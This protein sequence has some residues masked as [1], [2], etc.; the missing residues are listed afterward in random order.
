MQGDIGHLLYYFHKCKW[1]IASYVE[2][3]I[4]YHLG[5]YAEKA[6]RRRTAVY[7]VIL[8]IINNPLISFVGTFHSAHQECRNA[9]LAS[10]S[11]PTI[12]ECCLLSWCNIGIGD[13]AHKI[14]Y[15]HILLCRESNINTHV[16][17]IGERVNDA[18][19]RMMTVYGG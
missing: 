11:P 4:L 6:Y 13:I 15:A 7:V 14:T 3:A 8:V 9:D 2:T 10:C 1:C 18:L 19:C 17:E 12:F 5:Q 16:I